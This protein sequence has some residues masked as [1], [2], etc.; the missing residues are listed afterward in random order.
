MA[1]APAILSASTLGGDKIVGPEGHD[2][3]TLKDLMIDTTHSEVAYAVM[4][5]GGVAGLGEKLFAVPWALL[6][7]DGDNK[8]L[9]L[10]VDPEVLD[11]S[12]GFDSD[13]WPQ[14]NDAEWGRSVYDHF[15]V[16]P[17]WNQDPPLT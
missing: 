5:R 7:V 3:G 6:T 10:N 9:V 17:Y 8:Q 2:L 15:G 12:P 16:D 1:R 13:N 4:S 11:N 14:F